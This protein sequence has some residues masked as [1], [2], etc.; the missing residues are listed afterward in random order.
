[1]E[2]W[3]RC[4]V[5]CQMLYSLFVFTAGKYHFIIIS[6]PMSIFL[7]LNMKMINSRV[8][9]GSKVAFLRSRWP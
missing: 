4:H 6:I 5:F 8:T 3:S 2:Y 7:Q 9:I 1:M